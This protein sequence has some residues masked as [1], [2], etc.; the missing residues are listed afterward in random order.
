MS[1]YPISVQMLTIVL[2]SSPGGHLQPT[3]DRFFHLHHLQPTC[4]FRI[5]S[6]GCLG[7][8]KFP[9]EAKSFHHGE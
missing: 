6:G 3:I 8:P 9:I 1:L 4:I 2:L 5:L 7:N